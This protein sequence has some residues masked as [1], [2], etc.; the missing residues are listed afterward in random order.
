[1]SIHGP[2]VRERVPD[3]PRRSPLGKGG[4]ANFSEGGGGASPQRRG[5]LG[6]AWP[7]PPVVSLDRSRT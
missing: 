4:E 1:M 6:T 5:Q 7:K 3:T 2:T